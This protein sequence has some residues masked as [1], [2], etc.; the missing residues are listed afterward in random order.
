MRFSVSKTGLFWTFFEPFLHVLF[1]ILIKVFLFG[2]S[3]ENFD[4]AAFLALNFTAFIMFKNIV[5]KSMGAFTANKGLFV[6]KQVKPIDTIIA[7]V[8][9]EVFV[10]GVIILAFV[11]IGSYFGFDLNVKNLP[12]VALGFLWLIV[13]SFSFGLFIAV[14]NTFY[15]SVGK[16][17]N[18]SMR[19]FM[20]GSA[21]FYTIE[22]LPPQIQTLLLYNPLTHFMEMIHG[23]Y[24]HVLD[25]RFVDYGYMTLW[26][27][28]F[29]Y[30]GL[31][32]YRKLEE[33][34]ISL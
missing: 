17:I 13:F 24:F 21:L 33:R 16:V 15:P 14:S 29:L 26:T 7:R 12:M 1:F 9:V 18:I 25:D 3:A 10:T 8:I 20:F 27:L 19:F 34:I 2:R 11:A 30:G 23:Y 22:M 31:W 5:I 6:Y 28:A 32:F 4:Y